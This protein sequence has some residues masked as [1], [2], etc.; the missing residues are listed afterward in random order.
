MSATVRKPGHYWVK[1]ESARRPWHIAYW[2][3][4]HFEM[5][6]HPARFREHAF[7][8]IGPRVEDQ[9]LS[10]KTAMDAPHY[11]S[12]DT[13]LDNYFEACDPIRDFVEEIN[14]T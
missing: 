9:L 3:G 1:I 8:E 2:T 7:D 11:G 12:N 13:Q 10:I 14:L 5:F 6:R 4:V